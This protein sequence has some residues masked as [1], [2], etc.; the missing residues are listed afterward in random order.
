MKTAKKSHAFTLIEL[1][2]VIAIIALLISILLPGLGHARKIAITLKC[3]AHQQ[4]F[5][6]ALHNYTY[7]NK[8]FTPA[9]SWEPGKTYSKWGDL[10]GGTNYVQAHAHQSVDIVRR[11][12]SAEAAQYPAIAGRMMDRNYSHL[13]LIDGGF[14]SN[15]LPEPV[16]AC[17]ADRNTMVWQREALNHAAWATNPPVPFETTGN[18]DLGMHQ[19]VRR[20]LPFWST[21]QFIP[22]SWSHERVGVQLYQAS[23]A[24]GYH[25][26]YYHSPGGIG[27][28]QSQR[29][30]LGPRQLT[31][32]TFPSQKVWVFDLW[33]RH[34]YRRP[35]W[36]AYPMARQPLMMFDGSVAMRRTGDA[37]P[38][39]NPRTPNGGP[40]S[41]TYFPQGNELTLSPTL[42]GNTSDLVLGYY[43]WTRGGLRGVDYGGGEVRR[44]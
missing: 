28:P 43:R 33:D 14:F 31:D 3:H 15:V 24:P 26:L 7:V 12:M 10:N 8:G 1:L 37:N 23:G 34:S 40:T 18:P 36:H 42:S 35:I 4:Q 41:Y 5:V 38:G 17:P 44:Y 13:P 25:L 22:H 16:V 21:Y 30:V 32:V 20:L 19:N 9:F 39:W 2:M 27:T 11:M 6:A 29:T